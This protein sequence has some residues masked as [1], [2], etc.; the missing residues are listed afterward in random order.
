TY[1][2]RARGRSLMCFHWTWPKT[3]LMTCTMGNTCR[4]RRKPTKRSEIS[5]T[6]HSEKKKQIKNKILDKDQIVAIYYYIFG[7]DNAYLD[8]NDKVRTQ[9][10]QYKTEF[11]YHALHFLLTTAIQALRASKEDKC[12]TVYRRV[13]EYF[14]QDVQNKEI[15]FGSFTSASQGD[16]SKAE[17]FGDKSCFKIITCMGA[18]ISNYSKFQNEREVLIPPYEVFKVVKIERSTMKQKLPCEVVYTVKHT[19]NDSKLNCAFFPR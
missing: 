10:P 14:S 16:Y 12:L 3:L 8:F 13:N 4:M 5:G 2:Y 19:R 18:D 15:R 17:R 1:R 9:G 6:N 11:G 7:E